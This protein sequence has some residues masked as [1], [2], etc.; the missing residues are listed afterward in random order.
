[1]SRET[2]LVVE[3]EED[4]LEVVQHNL[5]R[6]GYNALCV[7]SGE[8]AIRVAREHVPDLLLLDLMLPGLGGYDVCK[9]LKSDP[10]TAHIPVIFVTARSEASDAVTGL[11]AGADD[12]IS[13]PFSPKI[14]LARVKAVLRR[15]R[16]Q[17]QEQTASLK[18]DDLEIHPARHEVYV[19]G[20][21]V[22]LTYTEFKI[23]EFLAR[24]PGFVFSRSQII[25]AVHGETAAV[26]DRSVDVQI[27]GLRKKLG[28]A[29]ASIETIRSVGYK[30]RD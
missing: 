24:R 11:E 29:G 26:T 7:A 30:F 8:E 4:I 25:N 19:Q 9:S 5:Q 22:K 28:P 17:T 18:F 16:A 23:L 10:R 27:V 2:V 1:M 14:L 3:D 21:S 13:K 20:R 6:E 15:R 12:F